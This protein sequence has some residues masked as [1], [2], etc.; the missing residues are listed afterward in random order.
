MKEK[1]LISACLLGVNCK[2]NGQNNYKED[3]LNKLKDKELIPFCP[4]IVG[5]LQTP[6]EPSEII[7]DKVMNKKGID[8]TENYQRGAKE[9]LA[10]CQRLNIKKAILKAKSPSCGSGKI[11]DGTFT[12]TLIS[13]DGITVKLL[14]E[15]G[16]IVLNENDIIKKGD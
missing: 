11:Y 7:N 5:G 3:L 12:S 16:I 6:R 8:V 9:A 13:G 1:I 4:E 10:L 14:K 15:N 2:Y